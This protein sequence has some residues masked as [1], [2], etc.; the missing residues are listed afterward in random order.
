VIGDCGELLFSEGKTS[1]IDLWGWSLT[2]LPYA[3]WKISFLRLNNYHSYQEYLWLVTKNVVI[4]SSSR[5]NTILLSLSALW[6]RWDLF[7]RIGTLIR[8]WT[9]TWI[10]QIVFQDY[11]CQKL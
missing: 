5:L 7:F 8:R 4:I 9:R 6:C 1:N 3:F 10:H 2:M 11:Q